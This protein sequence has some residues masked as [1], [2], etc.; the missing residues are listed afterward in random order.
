MSEQVEDDGVDLKWLVIE[1]SVPNGR[2]PDLIGELRLL[3]SAAK[4]VWVLD[5]AS[6]DYHVSLVI[7]G[8]GPTLQSTWR[9]KDLAVAEAKRLRRMIAEAT[10]FNARRGQVTP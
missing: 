10:L 3:P 6:D 9:R 5:V 7:E 2:Y 4:G 1:T 8:V